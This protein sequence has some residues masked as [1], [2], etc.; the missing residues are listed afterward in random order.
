MYFDPLFRPRLLSVYICHVKSPQINQSKHADL[1]KHQ[2]LNIT[3]CE[4]STKTELKMSCFWKVTSYFDTILRKIVNYFSYFAL[5]NFAI[6]LNTLVSKFGNDSADIPVFY[7]NID[8][9]PHKT[10]FWAREAKMSKLLKAA[11]CSRGGGSQTHTGT[12]RLP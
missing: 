9:C 6:S 2:L 3:I 5:R 8:P 1:R 7:S 4:T 10:P 11:I 12:W